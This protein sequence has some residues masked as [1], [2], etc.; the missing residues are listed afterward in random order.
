LKKFRAVLAE[1]VM[2]GHTVTLVVLLVLALG[3][4]AAAQPSLSIQVVP[5]VETL[6]AP[7]TSGDAQP[8]VNGSFE[9]QHQFASSRARVFYDL[10]VGTFTTP[11][12]WLYFVHG[13]GG[14]YRVD[15][16]S[17][18]RHRLFV[19]GD[20]VFRRNGESWTAANYNAL[21]GFANLEVQ[22]RP[23]MT[24]RTGYRFDL[25]RFAE[26]SG[27]DQQEHSGFGSLLVNLA[28]RTTLIGE[29]S[30]GTKRYA[31]MP[32]AIEYAATIEGVASGG[33]PE[34]A[35]SPGGGPATGA[36]G[37]GGPGQG[38]PGAGNP[39]GGITAAGALARMVVVPVVIPGSP[40]TSAQQFS[41]YGRVAQSLATRTGL[42]LEA[43]HRRVSG[44]VPP[45]LVAT[46]ARY[47]DDGVYD[48]PY[49]SGATLARATLKSL[50][51]HGIELAGSGSWQDKSYGATSAFDEAG[52][53]LDGVWRR[54]TVIRGL[55]VMTV[56][57][58]PSR[59]GVVGLSLVASYDVTRH[60]S[61]TAIYNYTSHAF[62]T[63][64]AFRY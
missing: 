45:L 60:R 15:L 16:G 20:A 7:G 48:D 18:E 46:P 61:T 53:P 57:L 10:D 11:G 4:P 26:L 40:S 55:V 9:V 43:S 6:S 36:P 1:V 14:S 41:L 3:S 8:S 42:S 49:A 50:V 34:G 37:S 22:Q 19:G 38:G 24:I 13:T 33:A 27:L 30:V 35:G 58:L 5:G 2:R 23:T 29:V 51:R 12:D 32:S 62:G 47:F 25:R 52:A 56:P 54:D 44:D 31:G 64:V 21:G 28:T 39:G 63:G 59:T 17:T